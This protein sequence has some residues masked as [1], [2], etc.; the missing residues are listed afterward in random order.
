[1][2]EACICRSAVCNS[3]TCGGCAGSTIPVRPASLLTWTLASDVP[4]AMCVL[5]AAQDTL[6][7]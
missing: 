6:V 7:M 5:S 1:M 2:G 3:T 4:I